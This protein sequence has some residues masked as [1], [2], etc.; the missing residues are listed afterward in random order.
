[1]RFSYRRPILA[2][3]ALLWLSSLVLP[4][5]AAGGRTFDGLDVLLRGWEGLSRGVPS[6]LANPF[7]VAAFVA[8][9]AKR[10]VVAALLATLSVALGVTSFAAGDLLARSNAFA[11]EIE[12][13]AG[14]YVWLAALIALCLH[15]LTGALV[16]FRTRTR[17]ERRRSSIP[18]GTSRD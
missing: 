11:P 13:R 10:V 2:L 12:L 9:L 5:V 17:N 4:A 3:V 15:A 6:W 16:V 8:A 1:M 7:F 18:S 14:F